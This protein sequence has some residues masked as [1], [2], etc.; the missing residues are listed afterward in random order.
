MKGKD[1]SKEQTGNIKSEMEE[2]VF[3]ESFVFRRKSET[4]EYIQR[5]QPEVSTIRNKSYYWN[6]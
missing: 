2:T 3:M 5:K 6:V 4:P 1:S